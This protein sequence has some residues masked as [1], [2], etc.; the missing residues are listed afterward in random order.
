MARNKYI[1]LLS[2]MVIA[3]DNVSL[4]PDAKRLSAKEGK[5]RMRDDAIARL[6][7]LI[8][9]GDTIY[10]VLDHCSRSGMSRRISLYT[11][12]KNDRFNITGWAARALD[13][14]H[15]DK[16]GIVVGG[17]GMDMGFHVVYEL[18]RV[19]FQGRFKCSGKNTGPHRCP[20][21]DHSNERPPNYTKGRLHS[22]GGYSL[23]HTWL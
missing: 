15:S 6:R 19:L 10:T 4:W 1:E 9:P 20:S 3:T 7:K 13:M 16:G 2:G 8:K 18:S 14:K 21:N 17:C 22:D 11:I 5:Q 12:K 23:R